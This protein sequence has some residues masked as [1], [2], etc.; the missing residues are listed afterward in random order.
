MFIKNNKSDVDT[1][2]DQI[3]LIYNPDPFV[4]RINLVIRLTRELEATDVELSKELLYDS[5]KL[6]LQ[7][8]KDSR[9]EEENVDVQTI[10]H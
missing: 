8:L 6:T 9:T 1:L 10:T 4:N 2:L 7:S 5:I 3:E